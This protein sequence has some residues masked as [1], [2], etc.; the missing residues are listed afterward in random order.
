MKRT[1]ATAEVLDLREVH[2]AKLTGIV[3]SAGL[4]RYRI[5]AQI[6]GLHSHV[7]AFV[8]VGTHGIAGG[9]GEV[10]EELP[11]KAVGYGVRHF[12]AL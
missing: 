1:S 6:V 4:I 5:P 10:R 12:P 11:D 8:A 2:D 9:R 7:A 3:K